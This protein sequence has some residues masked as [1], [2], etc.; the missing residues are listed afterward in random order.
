MTAKGFSSAT[1]NGSKILSRL[2]D[3]VDQMRRESPSSTRTFTRAVFEKQPII[4]NTRNSGVLQLT[5]LS[6]NPG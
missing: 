5:C 2:H 1:L 6:K 4:L 3:L